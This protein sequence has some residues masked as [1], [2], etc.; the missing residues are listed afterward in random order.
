MGGQE[1]GDEQHQWNEPG[2]PILEL[3][4]SWPRAMFHMESVPPLLQALASLAP[5][6]PFAPCNCVRAA[7]PP[8]PPASTAPP[9]KTLRRPPGRRP[10]TQNL[11]LENVGI[12]T[13]KRG[14]I[15]VDD[16][17]RTKVQGWTFGGGGASLQRP[18]PCAAQRGAAAA[19]QLD[20]R[21]SRRAPARWGPAECA[22]GR[23]GCVAVAR[24]ACAAASGPQRP[25]PT[26]PSPMFRP[27]PHRCPQSTPLVTS[28][29]VSAPRCQGRREGWGKRGP[30]AAPGGSCSAAQRNARIVA[31]T[32][33]QRSTPIDILPAVHPLVK[34]L[35]PPDDGP[36]PPHPVCHRGPQVPCWP[37][38]PRRTGWRPLRSSAASPATSTTTR[39]PPSSTHTQR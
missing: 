36:F 37:T 28:S 3:T 30:A 18:G 7:T 17:F 19:L 31:R 23:L 35:P 13:D 4:I 24:G 1:P 10:F 8:R 29:R 6:C 14:R 22:C 25:Q 27:C 9:P 33:P 2:L 32:Q 12:A 5:E 26:A 34:C 38:R 39:C 21:F 20:A 15:E 11:G 16:H